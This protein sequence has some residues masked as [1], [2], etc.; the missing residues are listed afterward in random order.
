MTKPRIV[1]TGQDE[2]NAAL[3]KV[4]QFDVEAASTEAATALLGDVKAGTRVKT[5]LL[6]S[7]WEVR[8]GA[9][10]NEVPYAVPQEFGTVNMEGAFATIRAFESGETDVLKA[11][12]KEIEH[13]AETAGLDTK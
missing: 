1:V 3:E 4:A 9:F 5:G 6:A 11:F 13:A 12:E 8:Q 10:V 7:S 2:V